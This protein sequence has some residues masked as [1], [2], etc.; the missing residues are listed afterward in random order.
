MYKSCGAIILLL[1]SLLCQAAIEVTEEFSHQQGIAFSYS[2]SNSNAV[3]Q[4]ND[5]LWQ[6]HAGQTLNLGLVDEPLWIKT[7]LVNH[8]NQD[9][10]L[11]MSLDN[12]LLDK[13][14]VYI[15]QQNHV[16]MTLALGDTVPLLKRPIKH[17]AQLV[18][19]HL[20]ANSSKQIF[21]QIHH[22][23]PLTVSLS[24]WQQTEYLKY[25]S[26][27]NLIYGLLAGFMLAMVFTNIALYYFTRKSYFITG[28]CLVSALWLL[29]IHIYGFSYRYIYADW[30]WLQ[31]YGQAHLVLL[32][33]LLFT[34]L[35][36]HTVGKQH[37]T[38]R[39]KRS[40]E[41]TGLVG[42]AVLLLLSVFSVS[43]ALLI[44]YVVS[45]SL[46]AGYLVYTSLGIRAGYPYRT[47]MLS[48]C[49]LL[50][51]FLTYQ[52][53]QALGWLH[54]AWL[55]HPVT[56][57]C[58][59]LISMFVSYLLTQQFVVQRDNKFKAQQ[60]KLAASQ[61]EDALL[62]ERLKIQEQASEELEARIDERTFELQVTLRE[63]EDK[64]RE[65]EK[66]NMEDAL[67][68]VK[69]RRYFDKRLMMEV[70]RARREQ[71]TLS[72]IM[73][74]I[75][76]FKSINDRFGHL[77]GDQAICAIADILKNAAQRPFDEVFRYGGEEFVM[78]LPNTQE[79]GAFEIA[80]QLR[81]QVAEFVL[82]IGEANIEFTISAGIYSAI[83]ADIH[84]PTL[85]TDLADKALYRAK[86]QGRN[87]VV[88]YSNEEEMP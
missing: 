73:L 83:A 10:E 58:S 76:H 48:S 24:L 13:I 56:Y 16:L 4:L 21:I 86:Q 64:N 18:P 49:I 74:D 41:I 88:I 87:R 82:R 60:Q 25:K 9:F 57:L 30:Q 11:L 72:I 84:N 8:S 31:Q 37:L 67:T 19:V 40:L 35:I 79:E 59:L 33:T 63:L 70:R 75:D 45:L 17:E 66:L 69:N 77:V 1:F 52:A 80:E 42:I 7:E 54:Q 36:W 22:Q 71:S 12:N 81:S 44:S 61:A 6:P 23:G 43:T 85:Y 46:T 26:R 39:A 47:A 34:P 65:L 50:L 32:A 14:T 68:K 51:L 53:C 20:L 5:V 55:E 62:K 78:L 2:L 3:T 15:Q 28:A 29:V 38:H 27:F